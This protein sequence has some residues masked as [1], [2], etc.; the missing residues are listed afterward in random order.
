[1][2]IVPMRPSGLRLSKYNTVCVRGS[3]HSQE[4]PLHLRSKLTALRFLLY[5]AHGPIQ[6][7]AK[8]CTHESLIE[9]L[10]LEIRGLMCV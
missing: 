1:M 6:Q 4:N 2:L 7:A 3:S 9:V 8:P 10:I 5:E